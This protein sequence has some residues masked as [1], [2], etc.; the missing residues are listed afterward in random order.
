MFKIRGR[1]HGFIEK[2]HF[3]EYINTFI[4]LN[5]INTYTFICYKR[6][7]I[8]FVKFQLLSFNIANDNCI[9][10]SCPLHY[11]K[12]YAILVLYSQLLHSV[13]NQPKATR[14][15]FHG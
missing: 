4:I 7:F 2:N 1:V 15:N 12:V 9:L 10:L 11:N 6:I 14:H 5:S 8:V 13:T 3:S